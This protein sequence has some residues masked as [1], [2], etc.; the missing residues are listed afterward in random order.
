[1][2]EDA[3]QLQLAAGFSSISYTDYNRFKEKLRKV[4]INYKH[5]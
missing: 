1:M 3:K 5:I 2:L 4:S